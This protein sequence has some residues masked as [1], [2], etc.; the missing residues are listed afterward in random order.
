MKVQKKLWRLINLKTQAVLKGPEKLPDNW[1]GIFGLA[2][3]KD[4]LH[5]LSWMG[6]SYAGLGWEEIVVDVEE[7]PPEVLV[8]NRVRELLA[9][10]DWTMLPDVPMTVG[11]KQDWIAYRRAL[12]E[13]KHQPKFPHNIQWPAPPE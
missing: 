2:G 10:T 9:A 6:P 11:K 3:I 7:V 4:K 13:V 12:R 1:A 8:K 5:E